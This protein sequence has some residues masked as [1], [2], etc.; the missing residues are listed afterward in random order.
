MVKVA[1]V[2][3]AFAVPLT[4][5]YV[6]VIVVSPTLRPASR[7]V[8]LTVAIAIA[9]DYHVTIADRSAVVASLYMPVAVSCTEVPA[10]T[11]GIVG[12][13]AIERSTTGGGPPH[14][15]SPTNKNHTRAPGT[16][17]GECISPCV[18]KRASGIQP[19]CCVKPAPNH[20]S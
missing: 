10:A 18:S 14:A 15:T 19:I 3:V 1:A 9:D 16:P 17:R 5:P 11:V 2:T 7:P 20:I 13:I 4:A 12:V 6:A 8:G